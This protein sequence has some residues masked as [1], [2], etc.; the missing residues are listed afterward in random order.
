MLQLRSIVGIEYNHH[1]TGTTASGTIDP[2]MRRL[3]LQLEHP[4]GAK[5]TLDTS[6]EMDEHTRAVR[7]FDVRLKSGGTDQ[8]AE[9]LTTIVLAPHD[10]TDPTHICIADLLPQLITRNYGCRWK[11]CIDDVIF[12]TVL[13]N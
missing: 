6:I 10:V 3:H 1:K 13:S 4:E 11:L 8:P 12:D 2:S 9:L 7:I 5:A